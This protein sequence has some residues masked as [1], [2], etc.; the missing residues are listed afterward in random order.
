MP[1]DVI[2][3][4]HELW[5]RRL[6]LPAYAVKDAARYSNTKPTTV[7]DWYYGNSPILTP[8]EQGKPLSYMQLIEVAF[9]AFFRRLGIS[10]QR[11]RKSKDYVAQNFAVEYPFVQYRFKTEGHHILMEYLKLEPSHEFDKNNLIVTDSKGQLAWG[12]VISEKFAEFEYEHELALRWH[13]AGTTSAVLIDPR[14]AFGA[15][16]VNGVPTWAI[17][18]RWI[19]G[20]SIEEIEDDFSLDKNFIIDGLEFEGV[21]VNGNPVLG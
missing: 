17:R 19:A 14:I 4:E 1:N 7:N 13:P 5:Y 6:F 11:I 12:N 2:E 20:E 9:V 15:P 21:K 10:M 8:K 18:G 3:R 16:M